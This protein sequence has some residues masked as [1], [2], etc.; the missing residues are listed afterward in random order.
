M[1]KPKRPSKFLNQHLHSWTSSSLQHPA[2]ERTH[3]KFRVQPDRPC[4]RLRRRKPTR[5]ACLNEN[6]RSTETRFVGSTPFSKKLPALNGK[7]GNGA[8]HQSHASGESEGA[9]NRRRRKKRARGGKRAKRAEHHTAGKRSPPFSRQQVR[10]PIEDR[11]LE[12]GAPSEGSWTAARGTAARNT[13]S[14][15]GS[16]QAFLHHW[17]PSGCPPRNSLIFRCCTD[18]VCPYALIMPAGWNKMTK[19]GSPEGRPNELVQGI[20]GLT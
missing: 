6:P 15:R 11:F 14:T 16:I 9:T 7:M 20:R 5:S 1:P 19:D 10:F 12:T 2:E 18:P 4:W 8:Q 3:W 13:G 17:H